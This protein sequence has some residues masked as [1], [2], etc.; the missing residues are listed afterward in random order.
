MS[1]QH[2]IEHSGSDTKAA[3]RE[4]A[5]CLHN[6][7]IQSAVRGRSGSDEDQRRC[8]LWRLGSSQGWLGSPGV[9]VVS[10]EIALKA[11]IENRRLNVGLALIITCNGELF[12]IRKNAN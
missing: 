7:L 4:G 3:G 12:S 2:G 6:P 1:G 5:H 10:D 8:E 9:P 11:L